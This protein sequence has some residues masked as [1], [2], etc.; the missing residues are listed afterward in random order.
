MRDSKLRGVAC[1]REPG[2]PA[3]RTSHRRHVDPRV[4]AWRPVVATRAA[5]EG[6]CST[7]RGGVSRSRSCEWD[8]FTLTPPSAQCSSSTLVTRPTWQSPQITRACRAEAQPR[9]PGPQRACGLPCQPRLV[10]LLPPA[11]AAALPAPLPLAP[12]LAIP[13]A[14]L[15]I[16]LAAALVAAAAAAPVPVWQPRGDGYG[17]GSCAIDTRQVAAGGPL[18]R[19][20]AMAPAPAMAPACSTHLLS[21]WPSRRQSS[22]RLLPLPPP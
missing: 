1:V 10:V 9:P 14:L 8:P 19:A 20:K 13:A 7:R 2:I 22:Y 15:A 5:A 12:L 18:Q 3:A 21:W 11:A 17:C 6:S 16:P 4:R